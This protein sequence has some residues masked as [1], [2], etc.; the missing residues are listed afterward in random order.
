MPSPRLD[1]TGAQRFRA[2]RDDKIEVEMLLE[3][4]TIA[5]GTGAVRAVK[6][7]ESRRQLGI[8]DATADTGELLAED[9][10]AAVSDVD[11]HDPVGEVHRRLERIRQT[12]LDRRLDDQSIDDRLDGMMLHLI[13]L[14]LLRQLA[15]LSI[16]PGAREALP[17]QL[18]QFFPI[19]ALTST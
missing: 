11:G 16:H 2:V 1:G 19:F 13:Q 8:A 10:L 6:R 3:A 5:V 14:D 4:E 12:F 9:E 18:F 15:D 7:E 17:S